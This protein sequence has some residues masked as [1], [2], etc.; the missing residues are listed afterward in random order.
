MI[1]LS[2]IHKSFGKQEVLKGIDLTV[3]QGMWSPFLDPAGR[4]KQHCC[5]A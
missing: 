1:T 3:E 4:A 2:N 5:A